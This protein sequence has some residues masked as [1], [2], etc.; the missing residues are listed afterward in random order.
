MAQPTDGANIGAGML[1]LLAT[2]LVGVAV[3]V[4]IAG[5]IAAA[6]ARSEGGRTGPAP[7]K[8]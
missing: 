1:I 8:A 6:A 2:A 4:W 3:V 7:R 5:L